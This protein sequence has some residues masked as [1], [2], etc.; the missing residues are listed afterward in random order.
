MAALTATNMRAVG[1]VT[2][3][4]NTLGASD[5]FTFDDSKDQLLVLRNGTGGAL[6]P[7]LTGADAEAFGVAGYGSIDPTS[8]YSAG[9]IAAGATKTI[10]L[11][12][13]KKYLTGVVTVT[14]GTGISATLYEF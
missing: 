8:G 2:A 6:T 5:T 3:T 11:N 10:R 1:A 14:G 7:T 13:I 4:V 12:S 9:S